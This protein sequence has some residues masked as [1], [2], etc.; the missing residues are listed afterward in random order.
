MNAAAE[1]H[2]ARTPLERLTAEPW[3]FDFFQA[4]WLLERSHGDR[5]PVGERGPVAREAIRFRPAVSLGFPPTDVRGIARGGGADGV[6]EFHR[7]EISFLGLYGV[8]TPLPLHYAVDVLRADQGTVAA[9]P[10]H[11]ASDARRDE[12][13]ASSSAVR[14]FLDLFHH[15]LI[16][17]FYRAWIKYR[18][19]R[20]FGHPS[21][22][23][24]TDYLC[25]LIGCPLDS[26]RAVMGVS[27]VR[28]IRYAGTLTHHPRSAAELRGLLEDYWEF[29]PARVTQCAGRW[30]TLK[31]S[32]L[33]DVGVRN[34]TLGEDVILGEQI[35]DLSGKFVATLG[36]V[37]W[38]TYLSFLPDGKRFAETC[39][40]IRLSR[41]DPLAFDLEVVLRENVVPALSV[42]STDA[43][44]RLG[45]TAWVRTGEITETSVTFEAE[46]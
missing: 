38:E 23:R 32:D 8:S 40:L 3:R 33:N 20:V 22:D 5:T 41:G 11:A 17:L 12:D 7:V 21:R 10:V 18:Y 13:G 15:R 46:P 43:A 30:I 9:S 45:Y 25:R 44:A 26:D 16:S 34:C 31:P 4:V 35:Y 39:S 6:P 27:P 19:N 14:D 28:M 1:S 36:P 37:D 24:I 2:P 29:V 42:S